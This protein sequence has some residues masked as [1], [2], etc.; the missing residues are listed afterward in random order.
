[1]G[2]MM[3]MKY[4][5]IELNDVL[6]P[7]YTDAEGAARRP[8]IVEKIFTLS[9]YL[10]GANHFIS[11]DNVLY[12]FKDHYHIVTKR[13][14]ARECIIIYGLVRRLG[15]WRAN[16]IDEIY[17]VLC[18][19][20]QLDAEDI[21]N[22]D[23]YPKIIPFKNG[24][25]KYKTNVFND[26]TPEIHITKTFEAN[27]INSRHCPKFRK[28]LKE[29]LPDY[30]DRMKVLIYMGYCLLGIRDI[31]MAQFWVGSGGN[32]KSKLI[33]FLIDIMGKTA[34]NISLDAVLDDKYSIMA[35]KG[36]RFNG[37][38]ELDS[39]NLTV[40]GTR[41]FKRITGEDELQGSQKFQVREE[42]KNF[43]KCIFSTNHLPT[44]FRVQL[45]EAMLERIQIIEFPVKF[46]GTPQENA[47]IFNEILKEEGDQVV[48]F[49]ISLLPLKRRYIKV[50]VEDAR[51]K[52]IQY[53]NEIFRFIGDKLIQNDG[54]TISKRT[55]YKSF[56]Y[57]LKDNKLNNHFN[58]ITF[59]EMVKRYGIA[60]SLEWY[61][62]ADGYRKRRRVYDGWELLR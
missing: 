7:L 36:K 14:L 37:G 61:T 43:V 54:S 41:I 60:Q 46:R 6:A 55:M 59:F 34:S 15:N 31:Q 52:W 10:N 28:T 12:I 11:T 30:T 27:H 9:T 8:S 4:N 50:D 3:K 57:W 62:T 21:I 19:M 58:E 23:Y 32:G 20:N 16:N 22:I 49:L 44:P 39:S 45:D 53:S 13:E 5:I 24:Y 25:L 40:R 33:Q 48:S 38:S 29:M 17:R 1:M 18:Q 26:Y 2:L 56:C 35:L 51:N 47:D 42:W